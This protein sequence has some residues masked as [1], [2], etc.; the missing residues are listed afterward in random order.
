MNVKAKRRPFFDKRKISSFGSISAKKRIP[1][2][3]VLAKLHRSIAIANLHAAGSAMHRRTS[4]HGNAA[5]IQKIQDRVRLCKSAARRGRKADKVMRILPCQSQGHSKHVQNA[6]REI[7]CHSAIL[8]RRAN[9]VARCRA[10]NSQP[11]SRGHI[12][13]ARRGGRYPLHANN[14]KARVS[15][16]KKCRKNRKNPQASPAQRRVERLLPQISPARKSRLQSA[17]TA[18]RKMLYE[19]I[20]QIRKKQSNN[21]N[22]NKKLIIAQVTAAF[23]NYLV[24]QKQKRNQV[25]QSHQAVKSVRNAPNQ[26][27]LHNS[28]KQNKK[29]LQSLINQDISAKMLAGQIANALLAVVRPADHRSK[30]EQR[31][32]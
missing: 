16:L 11:N 13:K 3:G 14:Q 5:A 9:K 23:F 7:R 8:N 29:H 1:T 26:V 32:R 30:G 24:G 19:F 10:K 25:R 18:M 17:K 31:Y 27:N 12:Q 21:I 4:K 15:R 20:L 2:S 22:L 6:N 28:R